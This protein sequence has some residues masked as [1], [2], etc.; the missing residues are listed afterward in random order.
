[1]GVAYRQTTWLIDLENRE[2]NRRMI[3]W[4]RQVMWLIDQVNRK[5][6]KEK[7][8]RRR[9]ERRKILKKM[10]LLIYHVTVSTVRLLK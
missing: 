7:K 8:N 4:C 9:R 10:E 5:T 1:M 2:T 6:K 3:M